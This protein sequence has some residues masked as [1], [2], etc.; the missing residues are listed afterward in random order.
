MSD[1]PLHLLTDPSGPQARLLAGFFDDRAGPLTGPPFAL[2]P[3][4]ITMQRTRADGS[5]RITQVHEDQFFA[6]PGGGLTDATTLLSTR[7]ALDNCS[8]SLA[9]SSPCAGLREL[10]LFAGHQ[11]KVDDQLE[12][13]QGVVLARVPMRVPSLRP[14]VTTRR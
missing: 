6:T 12:S 1:K 5:T 14:S 8:T 10:V 11:L 13:C 3:Y 4:G 7:D 9:S 2:D